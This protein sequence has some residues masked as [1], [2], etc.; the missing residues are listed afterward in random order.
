MLWQTQRVVDLEKSLP[1]ETAYGR[2]R[3]VLLM[4]HRTTKILRFNPVALPFAI[5]G[6]W[7]TRM[8]LHCVKALQVQFLVNKVY[9]PVV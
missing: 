3:L 8:V 6:Y 4:P 9:G 5:V 1:L 7:Q 2:I